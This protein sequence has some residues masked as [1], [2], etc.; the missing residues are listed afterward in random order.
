MELAKI[1]HVKAGRACR[2]FIFSRRIVLELFLAV[3]MQ[4]QNSLDWYALLMDAFL[5]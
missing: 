4:R 1:V 5:A 3:V 2:L